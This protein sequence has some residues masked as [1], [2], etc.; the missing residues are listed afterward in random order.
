MRKKNFKMMKDNIRFLN[1]LK[2]KRQSMQ[3]YK[4]PARFR[5]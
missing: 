5:T 2:I 3:N 4:N 1:G